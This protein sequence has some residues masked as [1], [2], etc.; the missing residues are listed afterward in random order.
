[1]ALRQVLAAVACLDLCL[2]ESDAVG[3]RVHNLAEH[4]GMSCGCCYGKPG[5]HPPTPQDCVSAG[6]A[7][8]VLFYIPLPLTF[9]NKRLF[10]ALWEPEGQGDGLMGKSTGCAKMRTW[11][12]IPC[13]HTKSR[14]CLCT[15]A[16]PALWD[17][18]RRVTA[19]CWRPAQLYSQPLSWGFR[20]SVI[21]R[22][23]TI[24]FRLPTCTGTLTYMYTYSM[25][26]H[27]TCTLHVYML[28]HSE[29][30]DFF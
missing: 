16:T 14:A 7:V 13:I 23:P 20:Y 12:W 11:V 18:D 3:C 1:M 10:S 15:P 8:M 5:H 4:P 6:S 2:P 29:K 22:T 9:Q 21:S 30:K 25:H 26:I 28:T 24:L 17:G 19:V 27:H